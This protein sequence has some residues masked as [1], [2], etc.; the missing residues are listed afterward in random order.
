MN[1]KWRI[2]LGI[3][4]VVMVCV[5][6][7]SAAIQFPIT[8]YASDPSSLDQL[9]SAFTNQDS[10]EN[11]KLNQF[12]SKLE[13]DSS[14]GI[15]KLNI[16]PSEH[17]PYNGSIPLPLTRYSL[18]AIAKDTDTYISKD[19]AIE[20]VSA[21]FPG[22]C[23]HKPITASLRRIDEPA[24]P[25]STE[26]LVWVVTIEGY[27]D[28]DGGPC[29]QESCDGNTFRMVIPIAMLVYIDAVTGERLPYFI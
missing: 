23:L 17:P 15:R 14:S 18:R 12:F 5:P 19:E 9:T 8:K 4:L 27:Y 7:V 10:Y 22:I 11:A 1:Q 25:S 29:G 21:L 28:L 24:N 13:P 26:R 6:M 3:C 16:R 2:L 20:K